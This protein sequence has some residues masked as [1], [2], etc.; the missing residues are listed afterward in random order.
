[1]SMFYAMAAI[2]HPLNSPTV[3][4]FDGIRTQFYVAF[5]LYQ[6]VE[7]LVVYI[8][9][10]FVAWDY[11]TVVIQIGVLAAIGIY[12]RKSAFDKFLAAWIL[13]TAIALQF[14]SRMTG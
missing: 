5:I 8:R 13:L 2:L 12:L 1:M 7:S 4:R 11:L 9:D 10:G 6:I 14:V 3:P